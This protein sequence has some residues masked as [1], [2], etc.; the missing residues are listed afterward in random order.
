[1]LVLDYTIERAACEDRGELF[2]LESLCFGEAIAF[3]KKQF[4]YLLKS[5]NAEIY[6]MRDRG[7]IIASAIV[8]K[9]KTPHGKVARLYSLAVHPE[10]RGKGYSKQLLAECLKGLRQQNIQTVYLEVEK[11]NKI[12][13]A[14]YEAIGFCRVKVLKDYYEEDRDGIKMKLSLA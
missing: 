10:F 7:K 2:A 11:E 1:M 6:V 3:S 5:P 8:L 12:A 9:R 13:I 4:T 14:L